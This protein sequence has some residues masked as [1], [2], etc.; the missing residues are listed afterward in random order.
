[1][2]MPVVPAE[3][4]E[5]RAAQQ[6]RTL[7]NQLV[8]AFK[9]VPQFATELGLDSTAKFEVHELRRAMRV[10]P[11]GRYVP[12]LVVALTQS[13]DVKEVEQDGTPCH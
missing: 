10:G 9:A 8:V 13:V 5:A 12:Q 4:L 1:M 7:H 6:R 2:T 3:I 11:D